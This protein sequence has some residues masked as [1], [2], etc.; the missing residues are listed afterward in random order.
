M[1]PTVFLQLQGNKIISVCMYL[2]SDMKPEGVATIMKLFDSIIKAKPDYAIELL[3]PV[4]PFV[5]G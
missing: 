3:K 2:V 5:F 1:D 4:Y